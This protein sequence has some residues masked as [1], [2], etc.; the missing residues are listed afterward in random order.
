[1]G[2]VKWCGE[3]VKGPCKGLSMVFQ[4][5][6]LFP[7]LTVLQNVEIG[8]EALGIDAAGRRR[9]AEPWAPWPGRAWRPD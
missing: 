2:D 1:A 4:T 6:A 7:W 9:R 5:F 3:A 8:L